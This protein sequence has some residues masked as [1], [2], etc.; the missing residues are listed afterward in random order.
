MKK[1]K[2]RNKAIVILVLILGLTI[3]P[4]LFAS[5]QG[6]MEGLID[7]KNTDEI[8]NIER[9]KISH[10]YYEDTIGNA[11][12]VY[13]SGDFVYVADGGSGLAVIDI[14]DPTNPGT[15]VYE[16][17][18]GS[19][20]GVYVS[21]DFAY[22]ADGG[23]GLTVI[24]ISD[25]TNPGT[26]VYEDTTGSAMGVYVSGDYAYVADGGSGLAVID[27][28]DPT[29]PGT[30]AYE[31]TGDYASGVYVSGDYAYVADLVTGLAV[32]D[33]SD[34]TNP[35]TPVYEDT[36]GY[37]YDVYVSGDYAYVADWNSGLAVINI[38]DPTNPGAPV[39]EDTTG[40]ARGAPVYEDTT[41][42]A[43]GV[44][45]SGDYAYV[46]AGTS[47]LA[48]M[49][50]SESID[51]GTPVYEATND[52]ANGIYL[53]GDYAYVANS[54]SGLA[55]ID[56]SDP[57]NPG[58][59]VYED[60]TG[61]ALG[62]YVSGDYAYV[63]DDYAGLAVID[64][65]DPTN[66]GT[67]VTE[68]TNGWAMGV[69]VSG[70]YAYVADR[71]TGLAVIDISN[72]TNPGTP[73]YEATT[74][75]AYGVYVSGDFAYVADADSGLAVIN[76]SDPTNPGVPVYEDTTG[77]A[78][79]V[80]VSGDYAYVADSFSG[81]A[82]IDISDPTNPGTP[83][84]EATTGNAYNVYVSGDY[85]YVADFTAGLAV[86]DIS[87]PTDPGT[88][89]Y[90][91]TTERAYGVYVSGDFA[92]VADGDSGLAVIQVR[93]RVDMVD[94]KITI[95]NPQANEL[96]GTTAPNFDISITEL[97]LDSTWYSL[98]GGVNTTFAGL[99]GS[100]D[101]SL[102]NALTEGDAI[103]KF[104]ANDTYE[105]MGFAEVTIKKDITV[106][107]ITIN[108]PQVNE[109][110]GATAPNFDI[111]I[112]EPNLNT[113]WYSLNGGVNTTFTGLTGSI[114]QALWAALPEGNDTIRFYAND[115]LGRIGFAEVNVQKDYCVPNATINS[116]TL[117]QL[118]NSTAPGFDVSITDETGMNTTWYSLN[119][120]VN[121]I[122]TGFTGSINQVLWNALAE[123]DVVI[124][125]SGNDTL[126]RIG[127]AEVTIKKDVSV[128]I[129]T[130]TNP[131]ANDVFGATA[132]NFNISI[133]E[134]NLNTT[135]YSLNGGVNTTFTGLT[136]SI[137]QA[138]WNA[139]PGGNVSIRFYAND[140][141]GN[142]GFAEVTIK[143]DVSVPIITITNPQTN[144][145]FGTTAPNFNISINEL[146][147]DST[148]Y[149]LNGGVNT[150]FTGLTGS[151]NQTLWNAL[152]GGNVSIRFYAND[153][154]GNM[155]FAEVT[156]KKDVSVPI[157]TIT[158]PQANEFFG[159]TA[160]NFDISITE[161]NLGTTWYSLNGGANTTFTGLTG[162][163][164][165]ALWTAL[166]EGDV[167]I[168][169][170][171]N[172]TLGRIGFAEVT[173]KKDVSEPII[174]INNVQANEVFGA[175]A[176]YFNISIHNPNL[177]MTWYS[178]NG[179]ANSSECCINMEA[180]MPCCCLHTDETCH[181]MNMVNMTCMDHY[182]FLNQ[183]SWDALPEGNVTIR[184][185][186]S[187]SA[188]NIGFTDFTVLKQSTQEPG[189]G[190]QDDI[191]IYIM[192]P[193]VSAGIGLGILLVILLVR[194][195][196][197]SKKE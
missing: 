191:L 109:W 6:Y 98:N 130:I 65:S 195:A 134:P 124:R 67:P 178:L 12:G 174:T 47:G 85:A 115:T 63:V 32:I 173:I 22:V 95:T 38:S 123:G 77:E 86:I 3:I 43:R 148:W 105:N 97:N 83:V 72:P 36:T 135:W 41:G 177:E 55:V 35:G 82:V 110:A 176:P 1:I 81:L 90:E 27:I 61:H 20:M 106:P 184:F 187:D 100:I 188:G 189:N 144:E 163:I 74:G 112:T 164:N 125:F 59:P 159:T 88:P 133:A 79:G 152:P 137:N 9:P 19:A 185:Y 45:V 169:F 75:W 175:T 113:T 156:I 84:Y 26:P 94:P 69:Y 192:V 180:N 126:G 76:I 56:I 23:S 140:S 103:I 30:P 194:K 150:T 62:V 143:K 16:D 24:N 122:F 25:P 149:S 52:R 120:G 96:F 139:L 18:T 78:R 57:T 162:S 147:L 190:E 91:A 197:K 167:V 11:S 15:P 21:G 132:P 193:G 28:S 154:A 64:I 107:I 44:Y 127:F 129:I 99:N 37:A 153:S 146:N 196:R 158:N 60:T 114:N 73:V 168:K 121:T 68:N 186:A 179:G 33:I 46:A 70:D 54:Y 66:P 58:T 2:K 8:I 92:Y 4:N 104:Y 160:P 116:P 171:A 34:P 145:A 29:N 131:Q 165:Q 71:N 157:I 14:S 119:G 5:N 111:S 138:L 101:Q 89:V 181:C 51:P 42:N 53:S 49:D 155:G 10:A 136:G 39:Y 118:F 108:S 172:D 142:M 17:T 93:Q 80:Y 128:P 183:T 50:I 166:S 141:A 151:I 13:V 182:S 7:D 48:V 87:D 31:D 161:L 40:N 170:Y 117:N 102:W